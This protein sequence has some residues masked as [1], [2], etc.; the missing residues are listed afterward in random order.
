MLLPGTAG[1]RRRDYEPPG[2]TSDAL[3]SYAF[4]TR[5]PVLTQH[6]SL[7][8]FIEAPTLSEVSSPMVLRMRYV[9]SSTN[10]GYDPTTRP[11]YC[12]SGLY[13]TPPPVLRFR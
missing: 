4:A 3:L 6:T 7:Q 8:T 2:G 13:Q 5:C 1:P 9:V 11:V 10:V 12:R